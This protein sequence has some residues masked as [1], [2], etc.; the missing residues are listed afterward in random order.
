MY[1]IN[2]N[3][4]LDQVRQACLS[5]RAHLSECP[6]YQVEATQ[7]VCRLLSILPPSF[8]G[9]ALSRYNS[10]IIQFTRFQMYSSVYVCIHRVV[11]PSTIIL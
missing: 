5:L 4:G 6:S 10:H 3:S 11:Q 7:H 2:V 1:I 8:L 9:T